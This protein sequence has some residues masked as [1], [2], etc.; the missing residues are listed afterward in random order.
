MIVPTL[1]WT[2]SSFIFEVDGVLVAALLDAQVALDAAVEVN[3]VLQWHCLREGHVYCLPGAEAQV[4]LVALGDRAYCRAVAATVTVRF[5]D[6]SRLLV[7]R[8]GEVTDVTVDLLDS[9]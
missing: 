7:D 2:R 5:L 1:T 9:E 6:A 3:G 4:E 8:Y